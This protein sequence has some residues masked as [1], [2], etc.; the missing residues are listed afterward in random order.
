MVTRLL[1]MLHKS[2]PFKQGDP[3]GKTAV[4]IFKLKIYIKATKYVN[5]S[6]TKRVIWANV[7]SPF[8]QV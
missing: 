4:A 5:P 2:L 1:R 7:Q 6:S 8:S 3:G